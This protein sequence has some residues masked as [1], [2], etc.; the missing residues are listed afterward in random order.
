MLAPLPPSPLGTA[1]RAAP[2]SAASVDRV[3]G[4]LWGLL[5]ADALSMP[6]HWYYNVADIQRDF[7]G[8]KGYEAPK[9]RHPSR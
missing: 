5:I 2:L 7:G 6:V 4:A 8:I 1:A 3:R 9:L